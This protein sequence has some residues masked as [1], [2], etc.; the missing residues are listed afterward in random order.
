M[1]NFFSSAISSISDKLGLISHFTSQPDDDFDDEI[2]IVSQNILKNKNEPEVDRRSLL[3]HMRSQKKA[4]KATEKA[5][6]TQRKIS[7]IEYKRWQP[8]KRKLKEALGRMYKNTLKAIKEHKRENEGIIKEKELH[9]SLSKILTPKDKPLHLSF[10]EYAAQGKRAAMEDAHFYLD[11]EADKGALVGVFD[12]H[13]G[14]QVADYANKRFQELFPQYLKD[15][16]E[17]VHQTFEKVIYTIHQEVIDNKINDHAGSTG[18]ICF[19]NKITHTIYTA[20]VAD[21]EANIYRDIKKGRKKS[22]PLSCVRHWGSDK[23]A[24]RAVRILNNHRIKTWLTKQATKADLKEFR[25]GPLNISRAIGDVNFLFVNGIEEQV[26]LPKPKITINQLQPGD[27]LI[28]ACDGLKD[29]ASEQEIIEQIDENTSKANL[30]EHLTQY[31]LKVKFSNDNVTV[32]AI[33][34]T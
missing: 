7:S 27:L 30:A 12:G 1:L 13:G 6:E 10:S 11:L 20:T 33:K 8:R 31:A 18:V 19:I 15:F 25:I 32:L 5:Q 21:S 9:L 29:V 26:I 2:K 23:E 17:N 4:Q 16:N 34:V 3:H 28:L 22:I 14:K 24:A